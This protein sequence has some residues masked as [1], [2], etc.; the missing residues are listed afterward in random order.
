[1]T[2]QAGYGLY[3]WGGAGVESRWRSGKAEINDSDPIDRLVQ[4]KGWTLLPDRRDEIAP[5]IYENWYLDKKGYA[6]PKTTYDPKVWSD[7]QIQSLS[8]Q[9]VVKVE[10]EAN[11]GIGKL[12]TQKNDV[13]TTIDGVPFVVK[14]DKNGYYAHPG[15]LKQ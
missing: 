6:L 7:S 1:M 2:S 10:S 8:R 15:N 11:R 5:G 9:A 4:D 3:L 14:Y 13:R 12:P